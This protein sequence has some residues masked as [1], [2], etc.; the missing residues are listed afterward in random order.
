[1]NGYWEKVKREDEQVRYYHEGT[2]EFRVRP[3]VKAYE[4]FSSATDRIRK[5]AQEILL[6]KYPDCSFLKEIE[7]TSMKTNEGYVHY[8][9][10]PYTDITR[11]KII[12]RR[13]IRR[14]SIYK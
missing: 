4:N 2:F 12:R 14:V 3:Y 7:F 8:T 13:K 6:N 11:G 9:S 5:E 1:M 10:K